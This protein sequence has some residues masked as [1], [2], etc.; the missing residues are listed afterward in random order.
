MI[1]CPIDFDHG[2]VIAEFFFSDKFL[3]G[4]RH[5]KTVSQIQRSLGDSNP[6]EESYAGF[7]RRA[8]T[9]VC[10]SSAR[11]KL[12]NMEPPRFLYSKKIKNK[13][14]IYYLVNP[15]SQE[16]IELFERNYKM[17]VNK[18]KKLRNWQTLV[19]QTLPHVKDERVKKALSHLYE[20]KI[21]R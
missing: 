18:A 16:F 4:Q 6:N 20:R 15:D 7:Y 8:R 11:N 21:E 2:K 19:A 12:Q 13:P 5:A 1:N 14:T 3:I 17:F 10:I 9:V